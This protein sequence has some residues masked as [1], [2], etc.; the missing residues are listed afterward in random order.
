MSKETNPFLLLDLEP[1]FELDLALLNQHYFKKQ[2]LVHPDQ[3]KDPVLKVQMATQS[4]AYNVA[5][6]QLKD[7]LRRAKAILEYHDYSFAEEKP[8]QEFLMNFFEWQENTGENK[9]IIKEKKAQTEEHLKQALKNH[10]WERAARYLNQW[11]YLS[12]KS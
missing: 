8:D 10:E 9:D 3:I 6:M 12:S 2:R 5:Y 7:P 4:I 11:Q 1:L